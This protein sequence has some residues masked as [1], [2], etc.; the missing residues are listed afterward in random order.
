MIK[1]YIFQ[2]LMGYNLQDG[3]DLRRWLEKRNNI[4]NLFK[5]TKI[6]AKKLIINY[7]LF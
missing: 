4:F 5:K 7:F 2:M 3:I 1:I 6:S